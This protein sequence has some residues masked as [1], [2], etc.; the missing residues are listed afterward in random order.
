[1]IA[2]HGR[3][4]ANLPPRDWLGYLRIFGATGILSAV[5]TLALRLTPTTEP[6]SLLAALRLLGLIG[7]GAL[8]YL[9]GLWLFGAREFTLVRAVLRRV[10]T[11]SGFARRT[12]P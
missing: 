5:V 12:I 10:A 2:A 6:V 8:S 3:Y 4:G 11:A 9:G 7:I 1:M